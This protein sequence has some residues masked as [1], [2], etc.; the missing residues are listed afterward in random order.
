MTSSRSPLLASE[1]P[2]LASENPLLA[3]R[4]PLLAASENLLLASENPVLASRYKVQR[5]VVWSDNTCKR[6]RSLRRG[7]YLLALDGPPVQIE[8]LL[9]A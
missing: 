7:H 9:A 3:S 5:E 4:N 8:Y 2:L 1:N 6:D